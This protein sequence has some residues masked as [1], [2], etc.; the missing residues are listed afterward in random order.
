MSNLH[1]RL[2]DT[3]NKVS[4][5]IKTYS[6]T[7]EYHQWSQINQNSQPVPFDRIDVW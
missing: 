2:T 7:K 1:Q 3:V 5:L 6:N 4:Q